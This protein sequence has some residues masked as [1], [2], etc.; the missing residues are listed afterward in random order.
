MKARKQAQRGEHHDA[1]SSAE[2][3]TVKGCDSLH[4][5][6]ERAC[7]MAFALGLR[8]QLG[9]GCKNSG[10]TEQQPRDHGAEGRVRQRD[11]EEETGQQEKAALIHRRNTQTP[12]GGWRL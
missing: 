12:F 7:G 9:A 4:H 3:A 5:K 1:H 2:E 8:P 10:R 6:A 11:Q